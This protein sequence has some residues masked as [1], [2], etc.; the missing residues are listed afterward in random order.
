MKKSS[1][2]IKARA[3][4]RGAGR[5]CAAFFMLAV[6]ILFARHEAEAGPVRIAVL[7]W[8][9]NSSEDIGF[10]RDALPEM[11][12]SRIGSGSGVEVIGARKASQAV[13]EAK[14]KADEDVLAEA[15]RKLG[16]DYVL[17]G[18]VTKL[19]SS[20]SIDLN[21]FSVEGKWTEFFYAKGEGLESIEGLTERL[22]KDVVTYTGAAMKDDG[23]PAAS[24]PSGDFIVKAGE[25]ALPETWRS[26]YIQGEA[27]A[28]GAG[29][30]DQDGVKEFF[31]LRKD[32]LSIVRAKGDE[33][34]V[35]SELRAESGG[36]NIALSL[37][38][39]DSDGSAEVYVSSVRAGAGFASVIEYDKAEK[40]YKT[41]ITGVGRLVRAIDANA[42]VGQGFRAG[43]GFHGALRA[44]KKE[45]G[46]LADKGPF[47]MPL[48]R[49]IDLYRF[50]ALAT[51][52]GEKTLVVLDS[53][54][55]LRLYRNNKASWEEFWRSEDFYGGTLNWLEGDEYGASPS[56]DS[57]VFI[58]GRFLKSDDG[59]GLVVKRN[60]PGGLGRYSA[61]ARSY[62]K[63]GV[64][65]LRL[66]KGA[67]VE[68]WKTREVKGYIADFFIDDLDRDGVKELV[69]LVVEDNAG[70]SGKIKSY[71]LS[72]RLPV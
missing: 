48:P 56:D 72:A 57:R 25:S 33:I 7:Q 30:L 5:V 29:D 35:V 26:A 28:F 8:K 11:L 69:M 13:P 51:H 16:A 43:D 49:G 65:G 4:A 31:I 17:H 42:L 22:A 61:V 55:H 58:E 59:H 38:D 36:R 15:G 47:E 66:D 21:L 64:L 46:V 53:R 71:I 19:G 20:V 24:E 23:P 6:L 34:D 50:D 12:S 40:A 70:Y 37:V 27:L 39:S 10:L 63:G 44:L 18:S 54:G 68:E 1:L 14:A 60:I 52:G 62:V 9:V 67:L 45:G 3:T 41:T 32:G 2:S